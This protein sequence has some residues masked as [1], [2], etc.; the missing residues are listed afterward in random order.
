MC[1][2]SNYDRIWWVV[3]GMLGVGTVC[4]YVA[5]IWC[6]IVWL[7]DNET[8][9]DRSTW[10]EAHGEG[11]GKWTT[12]ACLWLNGC[13]CVCVCVCACVCVCVCVCDC[14]SLSRCGNMLNVFHSKTFDVWRGRGLELDLKRL[15]RAL[16]SNKIETDIN[17]LD[18]IE[19]QAIAKFKS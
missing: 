6:Y 14:L 3:A 18:R 4:T 2:L 9:R 1:E 15:I 7:T 11:M 5:H 19:G 10:P 12:P 17:E 16:F 8:Q 13:E